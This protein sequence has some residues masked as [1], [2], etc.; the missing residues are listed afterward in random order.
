MKA[1]METDLENT[2]GWR[3]EADETGW[4][5]QVM[6]KP[7]RKALEKGRVTVSLDLCPV[8]TARKE[9]DPLKTISVSII[10][11]GKIRC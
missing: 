5:M 4:L 11:W 7:E 3:R 9:A 2:E 8:T 1:N 10:P 6:G